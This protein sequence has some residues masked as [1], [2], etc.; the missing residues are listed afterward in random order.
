M[1]ATA[2]WRSG[3]GALEN[4][5]YGFVPGT[6]P[7]WSRALSVTS[8]AFWRAMGT[9][10]VF[11]PNR[12]KICACSRYQTTINPS[13]NSIVF[14][15]VIPACRL[16]VDILHITI[17]PYTRKNK[18]CKALPSSQSRRRPD[19]KNNSTRMHVCGGVVAC[20][21]CPAITVFFAPPLFPRGS[22]RKGALRSPAMQA[23]HLIQ[24]KPFAPAGF[25]QY[26]GHVFIMFLLSF[27]MLFCL[28]FCQFFE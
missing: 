25:H 21:R 8:P 10:Q 13:I 27:F 4:A 18:P 9:S 16:A 3:S 24:Q 22:E 19:E 26:A 1:H 11:T 6:S 23:L 5:C 28:L 7:A 20:P 2:C 17:A 14:I 12:G 15:S